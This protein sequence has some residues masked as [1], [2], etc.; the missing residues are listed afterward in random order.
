M[1]NKLHTDRRRA[2][3]ENIGWAPG[4][5]DTTDLEAATKTI[6]ATAEASGVGNADYSSVQTLS[7]TT[8]LNT[9]F[10]TLAACRIAIQRMA[11]RLSVTIDSDDGT[12]DLR[13]RVYVDAQ[14]AN[15][16]LYDLTY[17]TTG[18]QL[19]VQD[20]AVG[21]KETIFNLLKDGSAHTFYFY[22]WSPGNHSPVIS[23]CQLWFGVGGSTSSTLKHIQLTMTGMASFGMIHTGPTTGSHNVSIRAPYTTTSS[24]GAIGQTSTSTTG[25]TTYNMT[26]CLT[27]DIWLAV[28]PAAATDMQV[29]SNLTMA[30]ISE[31]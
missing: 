13:C 26:L 10:S 30:L 5:K 17:S 11:T 3:Y 22:F 31:G 14:A 1:P 21:L 2:I 7:V 4:L 9:V 15:N 6:S 28:S 12:H 8:C 27:G 18:N 24:T 20:A 16:L 19:A 25:V 23:L 29:L